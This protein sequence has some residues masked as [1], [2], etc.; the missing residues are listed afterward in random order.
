RWND[1]VLAFPQER[2]KFPRTAVRFRG[3]D[4]RVDCLRSSA[5]YVPD[6]SER[7]LESSAFA[8]FQVAG[9]QLSLE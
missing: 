5:K 6:S 2:R 9:F 7:K 3:N 8:D 1:V 4:G